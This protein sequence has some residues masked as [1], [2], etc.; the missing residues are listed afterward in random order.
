MSHGCDEDAWT[1]P[2]CQG[3]DFNGWIPSITDRIEGVDD[4]PLLMQMLLDQGWD[5]DA[6]VAIYGGSF[7]C[8]P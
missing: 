6:I 1:P 7:L 5:L 4:L 2:C 8:A 3:A